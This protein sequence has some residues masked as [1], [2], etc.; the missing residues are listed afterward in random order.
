MA[1]IAVG[2]FQHETNTFAPS[3]A[4]YAA[5]ESGGGWPGLCAGHDILSAVAGA[6]IPAAGAF[7]AL[8]AAGQEQFFACLGQR[9]KCYTDHS[10][11]PLNMHYIREIQRH[12]TCNKV[13][14]SKSLSFLSRVHPTT[15]S[16]YAPNPPRRNIKC[17]FI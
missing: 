5:F 17:V 13:T 9:G 1:R 3:P 16:K 11:K 15:Q 7:E 2:G 6:N 10:A 12:N 8:H 14:Y 4:D